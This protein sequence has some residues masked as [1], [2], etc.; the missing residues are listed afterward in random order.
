MQVAANE[1]WPLAAQRF[2]AWWERQVIDRPLLQ[3]GVQYD[4]QWRYLCEAFPVTYLQRGGVAALMGCRQVEASGTCWTYAIPDALADLRIAVDR[5]HPIFQRM[6]ADMLAAAREVAGTGLLSFP[7]NMGNVGDTLAM[8][9][10]YENLLADIAD[11]PELVAEKERQITA[12]W[13]ELYDYFH[14]LLQPDLPGSVTQWLPLYHPGRCTLIEA[15]LHAMLS[16]RQV[17]AIYLPEILARVA[18]VDR[19]IFHLDGPDGARHLDLLLDIPALAGIQWEPGAGQASANRLHWLPMLKK[20]QQHHKCL[21]VACHVAEAETFL[22]ELAPEGLILS[23]LDCDTLETAR[24]L[25]RLA[26]RCGA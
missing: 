18:H 23:I 17:E 22:R 5:R 1:N 15:D 14:A 4:G 9:R 13:R 20:I 6:T 21:W 26:M 10:G 11:T 24:A 3:M 7:A 19:A 8:I 16:P 2:A 12:C 25:E